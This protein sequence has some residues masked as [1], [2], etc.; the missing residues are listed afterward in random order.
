MWTNLLS[1]AKEAADACEP[2][3]REWMI[4][5]IESDPAGSV[6]YEVDADDRVHL[7]V[8][9]RRLVTA[10]RLALT[11]PVKAAPTNIS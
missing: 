11:R 8:G 9:G 7:Y 1:L 3:E 2:D 6:T 4:A 10:H 5:T